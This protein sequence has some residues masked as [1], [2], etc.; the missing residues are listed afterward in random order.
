MNIIK[1]LKRF[2]SSLQEQGEEPEVR[3]VPGMVK[4]FLPY[5]KWADVEKRKPAEYTG[6]RQQERRL[7]FQTEFAVVTKK[8]PGESRAH[9]RRIARARAK[10]RFIHDRTGVVGARKLHVKD[11]PTANT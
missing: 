5:S 8:Y 3:P 4:N 9:R 6:S 11:N 1:K 7:N 10:M 2:V